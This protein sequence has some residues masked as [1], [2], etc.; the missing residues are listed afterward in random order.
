[1][2]NQRNII[3]CFQT[4]FNL[5]NERYVSVRDYNGETLI[6]IRQFKKY[7]ERIY[8]TPLGV[9]L[10]ISQFMTLIDLLEEINNDV[11]DVRDKNVESFKYNLGNNV[12]VTANK[13]YPVVHIRF[14]FQNELMPFALPTKIGIALRFGEWNKLVELVEAVKTI[15]NKN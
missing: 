11:C 3:N 1:M 10:T 12:Y 14:Y 13:E 2:N 5:G 4:E 8:P 6:H 7:G 9:H 15:L